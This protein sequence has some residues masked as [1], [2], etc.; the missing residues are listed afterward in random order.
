MS[1][2]Q[3]LEFTLSF[4]SRLSPFWLLVLLPAGLGLAYWLYRRE[5]GPMP[6]PRRHLLYALR[7]TLVVVVCIAI[8][9][10]ELGIV[11]RLLYRGRIVLLA[12]NSESMLANDSSMPPVAAMAMA[13][14]L[15]LAEDRESPVD[16]FRRGAAC[17]QEAR[18]RLAAFQ[19]DL[20]RF[21]REAEQTARAAERLADQMTIAFL[22][23]AQ[24]EE[25]V[26]VRRL[27]EEQQ[28]EF[29][30]LWAESIQ[31]KEEFDD[32][33][34]GPAPA[35]NAVS[36]LCARFDTAV[37]AFNALQV[38][39]DSQ[40]LVGDQSKFR[41]ATASIIA[42]RRVELVPEIIGRLLPAIRQW[43]PGQV[44]QIIEL[45]DGGTRIL[46]RH[47][48]QPP[49]A[50]VR[51]PTDI[52]GR[53]QQLV[54]EE[55]DFP[56]SAVVLISDGVDLSHR[57]ADAL[58]RASVR[59][60]VPLFCAGVGHVQE[61]FDMAIERLSVP[62]I[63]VLGQPVTVG[64][65]VKAAVPL[66]ATCSVTIH[67]D[68]E[69]MTKQTVEL[70]NPH[71]IIYLS[72]TP[73]RLGL[74]RYRVSLH[75]SG[76]DLFVDRNNHAEFVLEAR[77]RPV[78]VLLLDDRPYWQTRFALN[79]FSRLPYVDLNPIIRITAP[80]GIVRRGV[81]KGMW[82]DSAAALSIYDLIVI[83]RFD[84]DVL[85]ERE[86]AQIDAFL[87]VEGKAVAFLSPGSA[88]HY[89][90][91]L[92][93]RLPFRVDGVAELPE[94]ALG[95]AG[96]RG[97]FLRV[98]D[99]GTLHPLTRGLARAL[100]GE[101]FPGVSLEPH[102]CVLLFRPA[103]AQ[104]LVSCR[105][106]GNGRVFAV[107]GDQLWRHLNQHAL[108]AHGALFSNLVTWSLG[109]FDKGVAVDQNVLTE[110]EPFQVWFAETGADATVHGADGG[111]IAH[112]RSEPARSA[113]GL[114]RA[115]FQPLPPGRY[116]LQAGAARPSEPLHVLE[117]H[118]ELL[119]LAQDRTYLKQLA[120]LSG[121][122]YRELAEIDHVF[123]GI[124]LKERREIRR[125]VF[126]FWS[127]PITLLAILLILSAEW[128][129]RKRWRLV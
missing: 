28:E 70:R 110:G 33:F 50:A 80:D 61:P 37:A 5:I 126:P 31:L 17:L 54:D 79:I 34:A 10:P 76:T 86:W 106:V 119:R 14:A 107:A 51:G 58:L 90:E 38:E 18:D 56:L 57:D 117:D 78:R 97:A 3:S 48:D 69:E 115:R 44:V 25:R 24:E 128:I 72:M 12:D 73:G 20:S 83:G 60:R 8:F 100:A 98:T 68:D 111:E 47:D 49:P 88:R 15:L 127:S 45:M 75:G 11:R 43:T 112:A 41:D 129:L 39:I 105:F 123:P 52:L 124:P 85:T 95:R 7:L 125:Q 30:R 103:L 99:E 84:R 4:A 46:D 23:L 27:P 2:E 71:Q 53:L 55:H 19:R 77:D 81:D 122:E 40:E 89:S 94:V 82:P 96:R 87:A 113:R 26:P 66:P 32:L 9:M 6:A 1:P 102:A 13:R 35:A 74:E 29:G 120:A 42:T 114:A 91:A 22:A 118:R 109:S 59:Q 62:P 63:G 67:A 108:A 92:R 101:E 65:H 36:S 104:P 116:T 21:G 64:V 93:R 16:A 121:G